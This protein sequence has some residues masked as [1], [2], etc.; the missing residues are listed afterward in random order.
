MASLEGHDYVYG[1]D[2]R[3]GLADGLTDGIER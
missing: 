3:K 2:D 1:I